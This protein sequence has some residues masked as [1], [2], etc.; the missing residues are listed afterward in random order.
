MWDFSFHGFYFELNLTFCVASFCFR[1]KSQRITKKMKKVI[2]NEKK[3]VVCNVGTAIDCNTLVYA[4]HHQRQSVSCLP[5]IPILP[6]IKA[7]LPFCSKIK[8]HSALSSKK[9][10]LVWIS[11]PMFAWFIICKD[12]VIIV[13]TSLLDLSKWIRV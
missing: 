7:F 6:K 12:L 11:P 1:M 9:I 4:M 5:L 13:H 10:G 2:F 8:C 3:S